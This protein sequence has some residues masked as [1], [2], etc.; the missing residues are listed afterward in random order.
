M[1]LKTIKF[2]EKGWGSE[3]WMLN[4][5]ICIKKL[6]VNKDKQCSMHYHA[7]K[8]E[9]FY[10]RYGMIEIETIDT[11]TGKLYRSIFCTDAMIH[12]KQN[13]P[14]RFRAVSD[15]AV[16]IEFSTHHEDSDSY[17]VQSGDSQK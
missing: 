3:T 2:V 4:G 7:K 12:I 15:D 8:E 1:L 13:V 14:H 16:L 5:P 17:R 6:H 10:V 9:V 11:K